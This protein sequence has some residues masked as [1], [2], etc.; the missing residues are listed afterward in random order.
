MARKTEKL[1][2][3]TRDIV[4]K[5]VKKLREQNL[6]PAVVYGNKMESTDIT[7]QRRQFRQVFRQAGYSSLI[8]ADVKDKFVKVLVKEVQM[9]PVSRDILHVS[10][11]AVDMD[12]ELETEVP[13]N[14][15]GVS[16][17][18][19]SNIGILSMP[20]D[21]ISIRC[22]PADLPHDI[23]VNIEELKEI[24][25]SIKVSDLTLPKGVELAYGQSDEQRIAAIVPPQKEIV[26][27]E[28]EELGEVPVI[29]E[30]EAEAVGEGETGEGA[31]AGAEGEAEKKPE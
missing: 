17:A 15:V 14:L 12:A 5:G 9:H 23:E 4:G 8:D 26:E 20:I 24:G 27:E 18:V 2:T 6:I 25:D 19:K 29:G 11:Y 22:L 28:P 7:V 30:E 16:P 21:S 3:E 10:F 31:E 13:I 1:K